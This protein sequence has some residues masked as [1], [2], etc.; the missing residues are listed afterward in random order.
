MHR[1]E[2]NVRSAVWGAALKAQKQ[3]ANCDLED[4][5]SVCLCGVSQKMQPLSLNDNFVRQLTE[6]VRACSPFVHI[7]PIIPLI[8]PHSLLRFG[9]ID[10]LH[11]LFRASMKMLPLMRWQVVVETSMP[12]S[13]Y[14]LRAIGK[15]RLRRAC[16]AAGWTAAAAALNR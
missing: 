14:S 2:C 5:S 13:P 3:V 9:Y 12:Q 1:S 10:Y 4:S 6:M 16:A 8:S 15:G 7:P 11:L